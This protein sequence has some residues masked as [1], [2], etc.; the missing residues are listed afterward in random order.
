MFQSTPVIASKLT[1]RGTISAEFMRDTGRLRIV[2]AN[3]VQ[4]EWLPPHSWFA[5]ASVSGRSR[6]GTS[7]DAKDLLLLID[8]FIAHRPSRRA[9]R[10]H[11]RAL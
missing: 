8:N 5:I 7:P 11:Q 10:R 3:V 2:E 4:A 9:R 6:W 1:D